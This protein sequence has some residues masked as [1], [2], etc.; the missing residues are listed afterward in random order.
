MNF[1]ETSEWMG[2]KGPGSRYCSGQDI[3]SGRVKGRW[4]QYRLALGAEK[5]LRTPRVTEVMVRYRCS[6]PK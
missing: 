6:V 3:P 5:S 2:P 4:I 1:K